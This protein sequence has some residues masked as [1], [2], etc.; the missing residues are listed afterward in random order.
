[1]AEECSDALC[2]MM[3]SSRPLSKNCL[4]CKVSGDP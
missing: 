2:G 1:L 3:K 4:L